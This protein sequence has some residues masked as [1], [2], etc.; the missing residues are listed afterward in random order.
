LTPSRKS[1]NVV[2]ILTDQ[3]RY[4]S[5]GCTG[6]PFAVTPN[7]DALAAEGT[8]F[9]RCI[10][11]NAVCCPSRA[12]I[13]SGLYPSAHG[14]WTNGVALPRNN[15]LPL[16]E[17]TR[18]HESEQFMISHVPTMPDTFAEAGYATVAIGKIHL[19]PTCAHPDIDWA[20]EG[21][22]WAADPDTMRNW[23]GPYY[24]FQHV[25]LTLGHGELGPNA[26]HY[27]AWRAENFPEV[28]AEL[29]TGA[30]R[31]NLEFPA[32]PMLYKSC[33]P[34]E[35]HNTTFI[36]DRTCE[37]IRDLSKADKP[38]LIWTGFPDPHSPFVPPADLAEEFETQDVLPIECPVEEAADKPLALTRK[39][40]KR[41]DGQGEN[42]PEFIKRAQQ[43][44]DALNHLI[45]INV[46]KIVAT[47]KELGEWENTILIFTTDHG[48]WLGDW[49]MTGK[50]TA[51]CKS[52]NHIPMIA[53]VPGADWPARVETAV[54]NVD[55]LPTL[56]DLAGVA[57]P[58]N[59][60]GESI[61]DVIAEGRQNPVMVQHYSP[62]TDRNNISVYDDRFRFT[63]YTVTGEKEL[64]DHH[65]DPHEL[66]NLAGKPEH[67]EDETRMLQMLMD[68]QCRTLRPQSGRF[69]IW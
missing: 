17:N 16:T 59:M 65:A 45:D 50:G 24:G 3:Q 31:K 40:K 69:G 47:L 35:A 6:N 56:C 42:Y 58:A 27:A 12:S 52:L 28:A 14:L 1:P 53:H 44:T 61:G 51:C 30:H 60:Q 4:D 15:Q 39:Q 54:S 57:G 23:H 68:V 66:H 43:Y 10:T 25:E 8:V 48:D 67:Q 19:Q 49:G 7:L 11:A 55:I 46:G 18:R 26:G 22:R 64:Y 5:M 9:D 36:G 32:H 38:F 29:A 37:H 13:I 2:F 62:K 63:W 21:G 20:M 34:Q 41:L 33:L